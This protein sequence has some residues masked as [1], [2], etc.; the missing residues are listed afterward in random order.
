[1]AW[2]V[3][4]Q[5]PA[6]LVTANALVNAAGNG[7]EWLT[8]GHDYAETHFSPLSQINTKNVKRLSLAWSFAT[9]ALQGTVEAT[10]LMHNGVLYGILP[11]DVMFATDARTGQTKWRWDPDVPRST[12]GFLPRTGQSGRG[13]LQRTRVCRAAGRTCHRAPSGNRQADLVDTAGGLVFMGNSAFDG[14]SPRKGSPPAGEVAA[15]QFDACAGRANPSM[16]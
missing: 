14:A 12:S 10:P 5:Q 8:Y 3:V 15:G 4:A 9:E 13:P 2:V 16:R 7:G 1:M 11:W 6:P